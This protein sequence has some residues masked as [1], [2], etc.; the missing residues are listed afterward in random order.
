MIY[1]A[2]SS[3]F[4]NNGEDENLSPYSWC[5]AKMVEL[6]KNYHKWFNLQYEIAYFYNVYGTG[7]VESGDYATVIGIFKKQFLE[8]RDIT[9]VSPGTQERI[10]THIEDIVDGLLMIAKVDKNK[11]Y[12]LSSDEKYS[13]VE[14]A[15]MFNSPY[16]MIPER[17]G[18]RKVA[19]IP[20]NNYAQK[21]NWKA[22]RKLQDYIKGIVNPT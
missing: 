8:K 9:V 14:V 7:E 4:G 6:I 5:K 13:I 22:K 17:L 18:E 2:S 11:E 1:S 20:K 19:L 10:F 16:I 12:H 21:I 15:K 3:K